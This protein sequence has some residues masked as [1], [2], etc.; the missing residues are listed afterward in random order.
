M[1]RPARI[2]LV[3]AAGERDRARARSQLDAARARI[4]E[5]APET[6]VRSQVFDEG[7][8]DAIVRAGEESDVV[9]LGG[10]VTHGLRLLIDET[11]AL[12]IASRIAC[13]VV[14]VPPGWAPQRGAVVVGLSDDESSETALRFAGEYA[15]DAHRELMILH[16]WLPDDA[17][18]D[19]SARIERESHREWLARAGRLL[20]ERFEGLATIEELYQGTAADALR[21]AGTGASLIVL[22]THRRGLVPSLVHGSVSRA[23][24]EGV[25]APLCIVPPHRALESPVVELHGAGTEV[26]LDEL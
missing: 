20:R 15:V 12:T 13:P 3:T 6:E 8:I 16:A 21:V 5:R 1:H 4:L 7:P 11:N 24:L 26:A 2:H 18:G 10:L 23:L 17:A 25:R 14:L 9:V 19:A 22:G